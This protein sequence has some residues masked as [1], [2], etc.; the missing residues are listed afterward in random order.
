MC[1]LHYKKIQIY[2]ALGV[3]DMSEDKLEDKTDRKCKITYFL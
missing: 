2:K 3:G 1:K